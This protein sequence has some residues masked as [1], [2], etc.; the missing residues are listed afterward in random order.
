[1]VTVFAFLAGS[2]ITFAVMHWIRRIPS[3]ATL[4]IMGIDV[5]EDPGYTVSVAQIDWGMVELRHGA[6]F[7]ACIKNE[8]NVPITL[9]MYMEDWNPANASN[10]ISLSLDYNGS[11][12]LV[13]GSI[14]ATLVLNVDPATTGIYSFSFTM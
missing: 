3:V 14:P 4:K 13:D 6:T 8:S 10:F 7:D 5:Y 2:A 9:T 11:K 12:I 1:L